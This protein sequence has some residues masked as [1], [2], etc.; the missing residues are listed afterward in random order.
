MTIRPRTED[1]VGAHSTG[2]GVPS[3]IV[4]ARDDDD[5]R[6]RA[7][8]RVSDELEGPQPRAVDVENDDVRPGRAH[9]SFRGVAAYDD[10]LEARSSQDVFE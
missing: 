8:P 10:V 9:P 2:D 5:S 1:R 7:T 4:E 3:P 6:V